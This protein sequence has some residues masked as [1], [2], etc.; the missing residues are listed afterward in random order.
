M[1]RERGGIVCL[2]EHGVRVYEGSTV[3]E[4]TVISVEVDAINLPKSRTKESGRTSGFPI[5]NVLPAKARIPS[6]MLGNIGV[7]LW[8]YGERDWHSF[9]G[10]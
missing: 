9:E 5:P 8:W 2:V 6:S 1:W 3:L 4:G 7:A 10:K